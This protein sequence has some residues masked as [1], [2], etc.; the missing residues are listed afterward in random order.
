[1]FVKIIIFIFTFFCLAIP[2]NSEELYK[3]DI[4]DKIEIE[5]N[6]N[7]YNNYLKKGMRAFADGS[8]N[9]LYNIKKK[10]KKWIEAHIVLN[11]PE[12]KKIKAKIRIMGDIKDH[13][14]L[15][16]TSLKVK[17]A[18]DSFYGVTRFNLFLPHTREGTNEV[19]WTL[20]LKYIKFP[21]LYSRIIEVKFNGKKYD[22]IFQEDA[23]KEFLERNAF[24]E[25]VI[26]KNNDYKLHLNEVSKDFYENFF[27]TSMVIDNGN[28]IDNG[29]T[30]NIVSEAIALYS[31]DNFE[32]RILNNDFF[33][34]INEKYASHGLMV[35]NRKYIF[36]PYSKTFIPLYYDGNVNLNF[37]EDNCKLSL[38][39]QVLKSFS[40]EYKKLSQRVLTLKQKCI[41]QEIFSIYKKNYQNRNLSKQY[42]YNLKYSYKAKYNTI[43]QK[44]L[45]HLETHELVDNID[46]KEI[47]YSFILNKKYFLCEL[48]INL[49][50]IKGCQNL[51]ENEYIELITKY[52][53]YREFKN[54]MLY[55]INLGTLDLPK[56]TFEILDE[57]DSEDYDFKL[58]QPELYLLNINSK[59][60]NNYVFFFENPEAKLMIKGYVPI[61]GIFQFI[62]NDKDIYSKKEFIDKN[63]VRHDKNLLTGCVTFLDVNF[64][65]ASI[66]SD[67]LRCEDSVN[68]LN[69]KGRIDEIEISNSLYDG[70]DIDFSE[71]SINQ[72]NITNSGN[73]CADFSFGKYTIL[74]SNLNGCKDKAFSFGEHSKALVN[75]TIINNSLMGIV[76]KDSSIVEVKNG[77]G[78]QIKKY[79]L[80]AYNKKPEFEGAIIVD[81]GFKCDNK[82]FYDQESFIK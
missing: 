53:P 7:N 67:K 17:I 81:K 31:T 32:D 82:N 4:P 16:H 52:S 8:T 47:V 75:D 27:S 12:K 40:E 33:I 11:N 56:K 61:K 76:S 46:G 48:D 19:F 1:M 45:N 68:I 59:S 3:L 38:E 9:K 21:A 77:K 73:D 80:A 24:R 79:C 50:L 78:L 65:D 66:S 44:I 28:F 72:M 29:L 54:Y 60:K 37:K 42:D 26:L 23:T 15:P 34:K 57:T 58:N 49:E 18:D 64:Q 43:R 14:R 74:K 36:I 39:A 20:L 70:L 69:S 6:T 25:T 5:L 30:A 13:L 71:I 51:P 55:T 62:G 10:Y 2:L 35:I 63:V 41:F 22:A